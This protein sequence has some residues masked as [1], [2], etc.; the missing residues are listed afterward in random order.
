MGGLPIL[1]LTSGFLL[2]ELNLLRHRTPFTSSSVN[3]L[4]PT[5]GAY[6][7]FL[8]S[9]LTS[10]AFPSLLLQWP[11]RS[12]NP[13]FSKYQLCIKPHQRRKLL[14]GSMLALGKYG[15]RSYSSLITAS[16]VH[17]EKCLLSVHTCLTQYLKHRYYFLGES[18]HKTR[19]SRNKT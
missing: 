9:S 2:L 17:I 18:N 19:I 4:S 6:R 14:V 8:N 1:P 15:S 5:L 7:H 16:S 11:I 3:L 10:S 13:E 12:S